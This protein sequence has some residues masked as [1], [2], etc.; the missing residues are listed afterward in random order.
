MSNILVDGVVGDGIFAMP[1]DNAAMDAAS[2]GFAA[3]LVGASG[4]AFADALAWVR[5]SAPSAGGEGTR[6]LCCYIRT[7][8]FG[9]SDCPSEILSDALTGAIKHAMEL[10][11]NISSVGAI[12]LENMRPATLLP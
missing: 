10:H 1:E 12:Y 8:L 6:T 7:Y 2:A 11:P 5:D 9:G 4:L 3:V